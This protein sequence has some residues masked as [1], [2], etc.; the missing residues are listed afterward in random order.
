[1]KMNNCDGQANKENLLAVNSTG[2]LWIRNAVENIKTS[3]DSTL[4]G[5]FVSPGLY[6]QIIIVSKK[7]PEGERVETE[8]EC[9]RQTIAN[10]AHSK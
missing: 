2:D 6:F 7:E 8:R 9:S 5:S 1:M 3:A 10:K 4:S